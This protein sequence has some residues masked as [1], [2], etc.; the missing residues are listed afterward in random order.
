ML[1]PMRQRFCPYLL[2]ISCLAVMPAHAATDT[3]DLRVVFDVS[4]SMAQ[5]DPDNQRGE[6]LRLLAAL[7]PDGARA[8]AW[9]YGRYV[10]MIVDWG[11]VDDA[12]RKRVEPAIEQI[13]ANA[14]LSH[15]ETAL[16]RASVGW[17]ESSAGTRRIMLLVTDSPLRASRNAERNQASRTRLLETRLPQFV[18][19]AA[20]LHVLALGDEV[21]EPL[22]RRL[23]VATGG[24]YRPLADAAEL[25][26]EAFAIYAQA[27]NLEFGAPVEGG[28]DVDK[29]VQ[30]ITLLLYRAQQA[31]APLLIPPDS[32]AISASKPRGH[33][34][35][36]ADSF[37]LVTIAKPAAGSWRISGAVGAN[38]RLMLQSRLNLVLG[39][40]PAFVAPGDDLVVSAELFQNGKKIRKN[41]YLRFVDFDVT[42]ID[43]EGQREVIEMEHHPERQFKGQ[44]R[45]LSTARLAEGRHRFEVSAS[46]RRYRRSRL[47]EFE[48]RAPVEVEVARA[49][50]PGIFNLKLRP[51]ASFLRA[52]GLSADAQVR[53]PDGSRQ[54][55]VFEPALGGWQQARVET[56]QQGL[57]RAAVSISALSHDDRIVEFEL[58]EVAMLGVAAPPPEAVAQT[59]ESKPESDGFDQRSLGFIVLGVNLT[60]IVAAVIGW[61]IIRRRPKQDDFAID[62]EDL[63]VES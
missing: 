57:Y 50:A 2:L 13:H 35:Y 19:A 40:L 61:L 27:G 46:T 56:D 54:K 12:W 23:A 6:M 29:A 52:D 3:L 8:G 41:S 39:D 58:D 37:D 53:A 9:T 25:V 43:P 47:V 34:W 21:D 14:E 10:E 44:Y 36:A 32:P 55:A 28:F 24:S 51:R 11:R 63:G 33:G 15:L 48:V 26:P 17:G 59:V 49:E 7:L 4:Q 62:D 30:Q 60:L 31:S 45:Y 22:L 38:S 42:H 16:T 18:N 5:Q 1:I 20:E